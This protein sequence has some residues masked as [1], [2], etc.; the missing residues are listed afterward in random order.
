LK[1]E[2]VDIL[3]PR[4]KT[5]ESFH[6]ASLWVFLAPLDDFDGNLTPIT[7]SSEELPWDEYVFSSFISFRNHKSKTST[8]FEGSYHAVFGAF[9]NL[10]NTGFF[11]AF[12]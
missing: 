9:Q 4:S 6:D 11:P 3:S 8:D 2:F 1:C 5:S 7:V 12:K 10:E